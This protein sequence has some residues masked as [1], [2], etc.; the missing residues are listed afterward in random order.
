MK[1]RRL[2]PLVISH[3]PQVINSGES[4]ENGY[5]ELIKDVV[6][7]R[8]L[9]HQIVSVHLKSGRSVV[10]FINSKQG[11]DNLHRG[12]MSQKQTHVELSMT[13]LTGSQLK[14][15]VS[16]RN[17]RQHRDGRICFCD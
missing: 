1:R 6:E 2:P 17:G 5:S 15:S 11:T 9:A 12:G 13:P 4:G 10:R 16:C 8:F 3:V 14:R 7:Q